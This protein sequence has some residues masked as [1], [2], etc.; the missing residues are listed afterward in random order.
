MIFQFSFLNIKLTG[1]HGFWLCVKA[2]TSITVRNVDPLT[3]ITI[4]GWVKE[5][6]G[7]KW[8][9]DAIHEI[10]HDKIH[11]MIHDKICD[12]IHD[13]IHDKIRE[14]FKKNIKN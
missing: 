6:Q 8:S 4:T 14:G 7:Q 5:K 9:T 11:D 13:K 1:P 12:R 2:F 10:I 3:P